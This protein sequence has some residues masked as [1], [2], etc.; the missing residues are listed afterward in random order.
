[1]SDLDPFITQWRQQLFAAGIKS[2]ALLDELESHLRDDIE[3]QI[4]SGVPETLARETAVQRIGTGAVLQAEFKKN[5]TARH[6]RTSTRLLLWGAG[7]GYAIVL[8]QLLPVLLKLETDS[9]EK[10]LGLMAV[11]VAMIALLGGRFFYRF[12]PT[13]PDRQKRRFVQMACFV[14][15]VL[16]FAYFLGAIVPQWD[17]GRFPIEQLLAASLWSFA[18]LPIGF[19]LWKGLD[20]AALNES[21]AG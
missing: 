7:F 17:Y 13:L 20:E 1:M 15:T 9:P 8:A 2:P 5:H 16:W 12:L 6:H 10:T 21:A 4:K 3:Q 19:H 18:S 14:P 11:A